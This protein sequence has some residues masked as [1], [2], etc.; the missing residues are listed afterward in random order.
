M[1]LSL[2][3][4][5]SLS[6]AL[7]LTAVCAAMTPHALA[8]TQS[9]RIEQLEKKLEQS[10]KLID[11]LATRLAEVERSKAV[12][13][14]AAAGAPVAAPPR[15][16]AL[17]QETVAQMSESLSKRSNDTGLPVHGFADVG[18]GWSSG[19]DPQV[20]R[21]FNGGTLDLYLT[22]Q[23]GDRVKSLIE[24]A[25]EYGPD[26]GVAMDMERLQIGYTLSDGMTLWA[27]RFH[28]PFGLWNTSYHH[29]ANLQTSIYR[30]RFVDFEDKG[31]IIAAHSVGLW[32]SG[33]TSLESSKLSY[34]IYFAN[35][36]SIRD[37]V[38][39]FNAYTDD[40]ANKL[41]GFNFG[42]APRGVLSGLTLGVHGFASRVNTLD[43]AASLLN[44]TQV[45]MFGAYA[46]YDADDWE[47]LAEYYGF[48]N[49]DA[50]GG[51]GR[52]SNAWFAQLGKSFGQWTPFVRHE[53]AALDAADRYFKSQMSGRSYNRSSAGLRY[54]VDPRSSLKLELS[55]S[56]END[57]SLL[58]AAGAPVALGRASY[59][60]GS[61]QYSI[62]F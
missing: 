35:G 44:Q 11:T 7:A 41:L 55:S 15:E 30:P 13:L 49:A 28:T 61:F 26:G 48:R 8:D 62:A 27:G 42:Y 25:V 21:G 14:P 59:R 29:G 16:L 24:L 6:R 39:D 22:P 58:D 10:M 12:V 40:T 45:R 38:L 9:D 5:R 33:K 31:G 56:T 4:V 20:L 43:A 1:P 53:R 36:S 47:V 23:F 19:G 3:T 60:R 52:N 51:G 18:G 37:R 17:L 2:P 46:G 50:A 34:D 32:L 54:A 57:V